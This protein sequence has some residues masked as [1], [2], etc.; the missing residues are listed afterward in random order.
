MT[1]LN[2]PDL[3]TVALEF[4][5]ID[6]RLDGLDSLEA[7]RHRQA[8]HGFTGSLILRREELDG[9]P[10]DHNEGIEANHPG[11]GPA[12]GVDL[13]MLSL[14]AAG[15]ENLV[16]NLRYLADR[17]EQAQQ[18]LARQRLRADA[19][20]LGHELDFAGQSLPAGEDVVSCSCGWDD[21]GLAAGASRVDAITAHLEEVIGIEGDPL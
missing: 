13:G 14:L 18:R 16:A 6:D 8:M 10:I 17:V 9:V 7:F 1:S 2:A 4:P 5:D 11:T 3:A 20:A 12:M 19:A 15:G 21:V